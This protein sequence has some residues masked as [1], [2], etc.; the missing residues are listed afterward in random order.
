M[1][2]KEKKVERAGRIMGGHPGKRG[3]KET[4]EEATAETEEE[5]GERS[6]GDRRTKRGEGEAEET[7]EED[8][9]SSRGGSGR[10]DTEKESGAQGR[11]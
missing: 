7:G 9:K 2:R 8:R 4:R 6:A 10:G 11:Q 1:E 5:G 3:R